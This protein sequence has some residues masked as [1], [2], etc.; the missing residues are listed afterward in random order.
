[1]DIN[2][3]QDLSV[4]TSIPETTLTSLNE[5][6][7]M[8]IGNA[9]EEALLKEHDQLSVDL[10]Y[11]VLKLTINNSQVKYRFE[12]SKKLEEVV[13]STVLM[14]KNSFV[15]KIESNLVQRLTEVY[16]ELL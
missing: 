8:V 11:G 9:V 2:V 4:L 16:K 6:V 10:G 1:M 5:K 12:P 3:K 7:I 14:E 15:S 13:I